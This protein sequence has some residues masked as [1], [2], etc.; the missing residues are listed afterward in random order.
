MENFH[1]VTLSLLAHQLRLSPARLRR[2]EIERIEELLPTIDSAK[3]Y[4]YDFVYHWITGTEPPRSRHPAKPQL[5]CGRDLL[6]DLSSMILVLSDSLDLKFADMPSGALPLEELARSYNVSTKTIAR[7]RRRG[8]PARKAIFPDG[9]RRLVFLPEVLRRFA[10]RNEHLLQE[11][12][13]FQRLSD[14]HRAEIIDQARSLFRQGKLTPYQI[15][16]SLARQHGRAVETIRLLLRG[17]DQQRP[18]QAVFPAASAPLSQE[19]K[20]DLFDAFGRGESPTKLSRRFR[21]SRSS[22]YRMINEIRSRRLRSQP[23]DYIYSPQFDL[24][25]FAGRIEPLPPADLPDLQLDHLPDEQ[26][27]DEYL[28]RL[29]DEPLL[30]HSQE[31]RLF[32]RYNYLKFRAQLLR[33]SLGSGPARASLLGSV[34]FLL[35]QATAVKNRIIRANLRLVVDIA[36]RHL[37]PKTQLFE[38]ISD[39]N[40]A[41]LRAVEKFDYSRR[42][43]F[44]TYATWAISREYA[45]TVPAANYQ[46]QHY[47]T[48]RDAMLDVAADGRGD[49]QL[50]RPEVLAKRDLLNDILQVLEPRERYV[51]SAHFGLGQYD[52]PLSLGVIGESLGLSKERTRQ[53]EA[54]AIRKLRQLIRPHELSHDKSP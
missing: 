5:L 16:V 6:A 30:T 51:V 12:G 31:L 8:L 48:G 26:P 7:W 35:K 19:Q 3:D 45:R 25:G 1:Y 18:G 14:D 41:L 22:I 27:L 47:I 43:R 38:L 32:R 10:K 15:C 21:R 50:L 53:I 2:R 24:P 33:N 4:P 46:L 40:I 17:Y 54:R 9:R 20:T 34:E 44:S 23:I 29:T 49:G 39:G 36:K 52:K 13:K 28:R 37:G 11:G 42:Y